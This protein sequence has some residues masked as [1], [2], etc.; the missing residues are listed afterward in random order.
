MST[1]KESNKNYPAYWKDTSAKGFLPQAIPAYWHVVWAETCF[2][3]H[4]YLVYKERF[5]AGKLDALLYIASCKAP[6]C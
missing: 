5:K 3:G 1:N 2:E 6:F 4:K